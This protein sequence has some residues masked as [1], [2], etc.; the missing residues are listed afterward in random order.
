MRNKPN[1]TAT[2][3]IPLL[4]KQHRSIH[5]VSGYILSEVW[6][7]IGY[8][9]HICLCEFGQLRVERGRR[10]RGE[11]RRQLRHAREQAP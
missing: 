8:V 11:G 2:N 9:F 7:L 3:S 1:F 4:K 6:E 10:L 5:I